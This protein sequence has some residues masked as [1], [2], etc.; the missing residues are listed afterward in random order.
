M[1]KFTVPRPPQTCQDPT[2]YQLS[3]C[4][5]RSKRDSQRPFSAS[6]STVPQAPLKLYPASAAEGNL[7]PARD[8]IS[9]RAESPLRNRLFSAD[10]LNNRAQRHPPGRRPRWTR[11]PQ[12]KRVLAGEG[13]AAF[14]CMAAHYSPV[15]VT[16]SWCRSRDN[17]RSTF[18]G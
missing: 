11:Q 8:V 14:S 13:R 7:C 12:V 5:S 1:I 9:N 2:S 15:C 4:V 3:L 18:F 10:E 17:S 16:T 6:C